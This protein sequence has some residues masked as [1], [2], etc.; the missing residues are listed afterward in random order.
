MFALVRIHGREL[1]SVLGRNAKLI[2][3]LE[4]G[5]DTERICKRVCY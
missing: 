4:T 5:N 1:Q 2:Q 3:Y